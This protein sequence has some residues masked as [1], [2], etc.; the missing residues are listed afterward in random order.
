MSVPGQRET[1]M[2]KANRVRIERARLKRELAHAVSREH[3]LVRAVEVLDGPGPLLAGMTVEDLLLACRR[4]GPAKLRGLLRGTGA[5]SHA[6]LAGIP[7]P[8]REALRARLIGEALVGAQTRP[9]ARSSITDPAAAAIAGPGQLRVGE[10]VDVDDGGRLR[11]GELG[12]ADRV[13]A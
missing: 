1:A 13:A 9:L 5:S 10:L 12:D 3:A 7:A 6:T 4:V 11:V 2:A 8:A